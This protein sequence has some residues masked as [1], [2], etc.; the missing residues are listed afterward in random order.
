MAKLTTSNLLWYIYQRNCEVGYPTVISMSQFCAE[1]SGATRKDII[2]ELDNLIN[3]M[4]FVHRRFLCVYD[5]TEQGLEEVLHL[6]K[7]EVNLCKQAW[8]VFLAQLVACCFYRAVKKIKNGISIFLLFYIGV[9]CCSFANANNASVVLN[10]EKTVDGLGLRIKKLSEKVNDV[11]VCVENFVSNEIAIATS[12]Y[13]SRLKEKLHKIDIEIGDAVSDREFYERR[14]AE[15]KASE[16]RFMCHVNMFWTAMAI[17]VAIV[18]VFVAWLGIIKPQKNE[19]RVNAEVIICI[20]F[21]GGVSII[22]FRR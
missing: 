5:L 10:M 22:L 17:V 6:Q 14:Y 11:S 4:H 7:I 21:S 9:I 3:G 13:E 18:G 15:L 16:E 2:N 20:S 19:K 12:T 1:F 8:W